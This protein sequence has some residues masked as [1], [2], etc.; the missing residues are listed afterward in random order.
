ME[1][2]AALRDE[3]EGA[4]A[5]LIAEPIGTEGI[6]VAPVLRM[7]VGAPEVEQHA[8]ALRER[9]AVPLEVVA[10][11]RADEREERVE[12]THLLHEMFDVVVTGAAQPLAVVRV[13][14]Q[15]E[16]DERDPAAHGD[17]RAQHVVELHGGD[18]RLQQLAVEPAILRDHAQ[19]TA[20]RRVQG[21]LA[22][23]LHQAREPVLR[24]AAGAAAAPL[25]Q[26]DARGAL[27]ERQ[28]LV[29]P[30]VN[31]LFR[32]RHA[33]PFADCLGDDAAALV[34]QDYL[35]HAAP[36]IDVPSPVAREYCG[37]ALHGL[38]RHERHEH[39]LAMPVRFAVQPLHAALAEQR[40]PGQAGRRTLAL[41]PFRVGEQA[42]R[43][44]AAHADGL[45]QPDPRAEDVGV[46]LPA[47]VAYEVIA[48]AQQCQRG[49][50]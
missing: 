36:A 23:P 45:L 46:Q 28:E 37:H 13:L 15:G 29:R 25:P 31:I 50:G 19:R 35:V 39:G 3:V 1:V 49:V 14:V 21:A 16:A 27:D 2:A 17:G 44:R 48:I 41:E 38:R 32:Q 8:R 11:Q 34:E 42:R 5:P 4:A 10:H 22:D 12:A 33:R 20:G 40:L 18:A 9:V 7:V 30:T 26:P 6:R 47:A 43:L 24:A